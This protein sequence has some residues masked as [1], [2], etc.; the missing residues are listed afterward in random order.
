MQK[1]QRKPRSEEEI[2]KSLFDEDNSY[3]SEPEDKLK[4]VI[5]KV[6]IRNAKAV[7][8]LKE[9]YQGR[10]QISGEQFTFTKKDGALYCEA[11][12]LIP[13]GN[14]GADSP[15]NI[16]IVS[17]LIHKMLHYAEVSDI[18]LSQL[19]ADNKLITTINGKE[20]TITWHPEHANFVKSHQ[21]TEA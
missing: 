15:Y 7:Q 21:E 19:S 9:L 10:C 13:L 6:R 16:I 14:E 18:D 11:H 12:H 20:Y 5:V 2:T 4:E 8:G 3:A 1:T 17:P